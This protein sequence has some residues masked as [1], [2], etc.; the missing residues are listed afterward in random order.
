MEAATPI[1]KS[2]TSCCF[3]HIEFIKKQ[4]SCKIVVIVIDQENW[5]MAFDMNGLGYPNWQI[6][7]RRGLTKEYRADR[8]RIIRTVYR[9]DWPVTVSTYDVNFSP[10]KKPFLLIKIGRRYYFQLLHLIYHDWTHICSL[11]NQRKMIFA[12]VLEALTPIFF[13]CSLVLCV[14]LLIHILQ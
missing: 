8:L 1:I 14:F 2:E 11:V 3:F 5:Y 10:R 9:F 7:W 13:Y 4:M 12:K 6:K